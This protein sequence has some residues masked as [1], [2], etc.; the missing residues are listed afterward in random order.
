MRERTRLKSTLLTAVLIAGIPFQ[1]ALAEEFEAT[2]LFRADDVLG[3]D[4]VVGETYIFDVAV[5]N[6]GR[7]NLFSLTSPDITLRAVGNEY[8]RERVR[9]MNA[10]AA[11]R[12]VKKTDAYVDG[13]QAAIAGPLANVK[14]A[15]TNPVRTIESLPGAVERLVDDISNA[16]GNI[17]KDDDGGEDGQMLKDL[18]GY[19]KTKRRLAHD[20]GVDPYSSNPVLQS[21]LDDLAWASFA[22][23]AT[24]NVAVA[25]TTSGVGLVTGTLDRVTAW[26]DLI[27]ENGSSTLAN[28]S[29]HH[30]T[31]M[32]LDPQSSDSFLANSHYSVSLQTRLVQALAVLQGVAGRDSFIALANAAAGED[33]ARFHQRTA[34]IIGAYH[35]QERPI[36]RLLIEGETALFVDADE[37]TILPLA[38]DY[39]VWTRQTAKGM[40]GILS[41]TG[42]RSVWLTGKVSPLTRQRLSAAEIDIQEAAFSRLTDRIAIVAPADTEAAPPKDTGKNKSTTGGLSGMFGSVGKFLGDVGEESKNQLKKLVPE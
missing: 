38:A 26:D 30:L 40:T 23:D 7:M 22:G 5:P 33:D 42:A 12:K 16:V 37:R 21:E 8:A 1:W 41:A 27:L 17:S 6:D 18:I 35:Q 29:R 32:G 3:A 36:E 4:V 9:E 19:N 25:A 24:I 10:I 20:L 39:L 14:D 11:I 2:P 34:E 31:A 28:I 15:I 13:M